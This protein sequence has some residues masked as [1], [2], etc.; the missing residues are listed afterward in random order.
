MTDRNETARGAPAA[1]WS[2]GRER[3]AGTHAFGPTIA[4]ATA[5]AVLA[6]LPKSVNRQG[7]TGE[8]LDAYSLSFG[9]T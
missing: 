1:V 6:M 8:A 9:T 3:P 2:A 4:A 7:P 5:A